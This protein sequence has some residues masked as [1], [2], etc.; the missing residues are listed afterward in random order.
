MRLRNQVALIT[1][2][3]SGIGRATAIA[4][5]RE[6][7]DIVVNYSSSKAEASETVSAIQKLGSRAIMVRAD[8]S[9]DGQVRAMMEETVKAFGRLDTLVNSAGFT[10]FVDFHNLDDLTEE[11]WD[12]TYA[13]N[14]KGVF[15]CSRAAARIMDQQGGGCIVNVTSTA[16][17]RPMGSSIAYCASK[18]AAISLT[19]TLAR[20]LA[21]KIRVNAVAPGFTD[22]RWNAWRPEGKI[23]VAQGTPLKRVASPEDVAEVIVSLV[24]SARH[25][26]GQVVAVD[27]GWLLETPR[28]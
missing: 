5:A 26:T 4:L 21:P 17:L 24:A 23:E 6:G 7:V 16:G 8:V 12:R 25:V 28:S 14:V 13:V 10:R 20:T 22:T 15:F 19:T 27:G 9:Q 3:A 1:G 2:S 18:A 11:L